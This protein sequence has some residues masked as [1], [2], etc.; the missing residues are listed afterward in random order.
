MRL[1]TVAR[2]LPALVLCA[3]APLQLGCGG[4]GSNAATQATTT[5]TTNSSSAGT[6]STPPTPVLRVTTTS[7]PNALQ[8]QPYSQ[9]LQASGGAQPY[10][11]S[12]P[13]GN[14][15]PCPPGL[16]LSASGLLSGTPTNWGNQACF[17][18]VTDSSSPAQTASL[19][20]ILFVEQPLSLSSLLSGP[21][22]TV[23]HPYSAFLSPN[24]GFGP[25]TWALQSGSLPPGLTLPGS[26]TFS[27]GTIS[28]VPTA[29]GPY[30]FTVQVTDTGPPQQTATQTFSLTVFDYPEVA[31]QSLPLGLI[32]K[33]YSAALQAIGGTPPYSWSVGAG[34]LPPGVTLDPLAGTISG[35]PTI[36]WNQAVPFT[37]TDSQVPPL[38]STAYLQ[39]VINPTLTFTQSTLPDAVPAQPYVGPLPFQGGLPPYIV[40][41]TSGA[42]PPGISIA[43]SGTGLVG[44][45]GSPTSTGTW[46][47]TLIV[48]DSESAPVTIQQAFSIRVNPQL[49]VANMQPPPGAVGVPYSFQFQAT[50]GLPPLN[51][52][53]VALSFL[54]LS[55]DAGSGLISGTPTSSG[56]FN[57]TVFVVDSSMPPQSSVLFLPGFVIYDKLRS[58]TSSVP[59]IA[60]NVPVNMQLNAFGG[61]G[62]Y[63]WQVVSGSLPQ[64]LNLSSAGQLSGTATQTGSFPIT[65]QLSDAGP[66]AQTATLATTISV[67]S[68][69]GRNDSPATATPLSNG[70]YQASISPIA[71]PP[72]G[73]ANPDGDYYVLTANPGA[74]VTIEIKA[75][76]LSPPSPLDSVLEIVDSSNNRLSL[77]NDSVL[78]TFGYTNLCLNDD[79]SDGSSTDSLL[80]LQVLQ[81]SSAPLTFYAHVLDW[82]GDARPD[83]VY[84]ITVT[85]AN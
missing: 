65:L 82:R 52:S 13:P 32:N 59:A 17:V 68:S 74:T 64:G 84:T 24:G 22:P 58:S 14:Y 2:A 8:G 6:S 30:N 41:V 12:L 4:G 50:G 7:L 83:F 78:L 15:F 5:S 71:D 79:L 48:Q 53:S 10:R 33:P 21:I 62:N 35:T 29:R 72:N 11:W 37:I 39:L 80:R 34:A 18:Q 77:C 23:R 76:R 27:Y 43:G 46:T 25:Y 70:T 36:T 66:P 63:S 19:V 51:W 38:Q 85:G 56:G 28:G 1:A 45:G 26:P 73:V 47:F 16:T 69:L 44:F 3:T 81:S 42:L 75:Q 67:N 61:T 40:S 31:T 54:G 55:L 57:L 9:T 60:P 20:L 49:V